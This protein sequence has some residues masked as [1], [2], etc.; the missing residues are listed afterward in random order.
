MLGSLLF[1]LYIN[2]FHLSSDL[3]QFHL[4]ADD[5][6]LFCEDKSS[7]LLAAQINTELKNV[8]SWLCANRLSLNVKKSSYVIFH[9][10]Q[11]KRHS[12]RF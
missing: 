1:L 3:F 9:P 6:N 2:D 4:F 7:S 8:H 12:L 5:V 10:R 11:K